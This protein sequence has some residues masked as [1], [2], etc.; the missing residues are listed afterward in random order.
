MS[1]MQT[2]SPVRM[3]R[4][5]LEHLPEFELPAGFSLRRYQL[6]DEENWLQIHLAADRL[7]PITPDLFAREFGSDDALLSQRQYYLLAPDSRPIGTAS[8]WFKDDFEGRR[9]GRVH[10]V[11][12]VPEFQG[13]GLAKP[14]MF[15]VCRRLQELGHDCAYLS[16]STA[17]LQA[18]RLYLRFGF[19]P[20]IKT[21]EDAEA[22]K[23]L[24]VVT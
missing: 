8:A 19:A 1:E 5:N 17:R 4:Q 18:I 6:G 22:W 12:I 9:F 3:I 2:H 11:A 23:R 24:D 13:R 21:Q 20:F 14:L 15:A 7:Q 16:T 10:W